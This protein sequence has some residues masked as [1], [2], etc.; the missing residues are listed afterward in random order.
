MRSEKIAVTTVSPGMSWETGIE[1]VIQM[2]AWE[3][4]A[5]HPPH[6][7]SPTHNPGYPPGHS[8][9][10]PGSKAIFGKMWTPNTR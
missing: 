9:D 2:R 10:H 8:Q 5:L 6:N 3:N 7:P 1:R 4:G